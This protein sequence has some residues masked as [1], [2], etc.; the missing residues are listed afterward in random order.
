MEDRKESWEEPPD[1]SGCLT[2]TE[3]ERE[4]GFSDPNAV[5]RKFSLISGEVQSQTHL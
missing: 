4:G 5:P 1:C 2:P 3:G